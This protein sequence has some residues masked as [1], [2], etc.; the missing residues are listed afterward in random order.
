MYLAVYIFRYGDIFWNRTSIYLTIMKLTY[1]CITLYI[2][3]LV[4]V[5]KPYCLVG[6]VDSRATTSTRTASTTTS[7]STRPCWC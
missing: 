1:I 6:W 7:T 4:R 3:Y 5:K 2:I